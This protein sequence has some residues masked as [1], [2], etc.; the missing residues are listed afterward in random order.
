MATSY[1]YSPH[2]PEQQIIKQYNAALVV[3]FYLCWSYSP[4]ANAQETIET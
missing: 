2:I 1:N 3:V 4:R